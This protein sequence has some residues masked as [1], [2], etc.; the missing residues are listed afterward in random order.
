MTEFALW[1]RQRI[2]RLGLAVV[3][4]VLESLVE[5]I[6]SRIGHTYLRFVQETL[7]PKG[8]DGGG[9]PYYFFATLSKDD[10]SELNMWKWL[11]E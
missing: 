7:H 9:L 8:W 5:A 4:G 2:S 10:C 3:V 11:L 1:H 6:P